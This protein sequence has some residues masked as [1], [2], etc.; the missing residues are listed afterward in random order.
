MSLF[1]HRPRY[2][3]GL[4]KREHI[5]QETGDWL[6]AYYGARYCRRRIPCYGLPR[7]YCWTTKD[8]IDGPVT[9]KYR[10]LLK[11]IMR[12]RARRENKQLLQE[13]Q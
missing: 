5:E 10:R 13:E 6:L 4:S 1:D 12:K 9:S 8:R 2:H 7:D 11:R 3:H